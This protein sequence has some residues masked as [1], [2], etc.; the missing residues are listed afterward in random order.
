MTEAKELL[1]ALKDQPTY[2]N[3]AADMGKKIVQIKGRNS[4]EQRKI[5]GLFALTREMLVKNINSKLLRDLE[6]DV[7]AAEAIIAKGGVWKRKSKEDDTVGSA[8]A[9]APKAD[10]PAALAPSATKDAAPPDAS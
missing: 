4:V 9:P 10:A 1:Q 5:D 8:P 7:A 2:E 6:V 3:I